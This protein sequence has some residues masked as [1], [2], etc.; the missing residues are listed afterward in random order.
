MF[1]RVGAARRNVRERRFPLGT[2]PAQHVPPQPD[3]ERGH[4]GAGELLIPART[5]PTPTAPGQA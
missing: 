2:L 3:Q 5:G 4:L 1:G